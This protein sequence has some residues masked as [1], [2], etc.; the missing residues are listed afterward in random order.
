[1]KYICVTAT[2]KRIELEHLA[3][4]STNPAFI[5]ARDFLLSLNT[6]RSNVFMEAAEKSR[7]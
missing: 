5:H 3:W 1:M 6:I 7:R 2:P 4:L